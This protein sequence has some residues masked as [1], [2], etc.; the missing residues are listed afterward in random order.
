MTLEPVPTCCQCGQESAFAPSFAFP[1]S[2]VCEHCRA[3]QRAPQ[4]EAM[5]L[6]TPAPATMA[7]QTQMEV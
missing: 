6:F 1:A 3:V 2:V 7:G 5:S 4:G